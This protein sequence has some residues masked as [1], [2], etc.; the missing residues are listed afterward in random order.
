M[1]WSLLGF[2]GKLVVHMCKLVVETFMGRVLVGCLSTVLV[3]F[4]L[5]TGKFSMW[6]LVEFWERMS[7]GRVFVQS[8]NKVGVVAVLGRLLLMGFMYRVLDVDRFGVGK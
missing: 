4:L 3:R 8:M 7:I 6:L 1:G 2:M 5:V